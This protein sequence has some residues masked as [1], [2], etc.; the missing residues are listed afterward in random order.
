MPRTR[1]L[2]SRPR[3]RLALVTAGLVMASTVGIG[4]APSTASATTPAPACAKVDK[5]RVVLQ[6]VA[7][8][9]F[10][11][12][13]AANDQGLYAKH[14]L[15]VEIQEGGVNIVPQTVLASGN[16]EFAVTHVVKSMVS[17]EEG[18]D[19]VNISQVFQ[20]GGYLQVS[21][22]DSGIKT[23]QDL[24]GKKVGSWGFG[25]ELILYGAMRD[26]GLEPEKDST[27]VQQP[28]DMSLLLRREIDAAQAKTY[29][30]YAQLLEATNPATGEL[31]KPEDFTFLDFN[32]LGYAS[33]EDGVYARGDWLADSANQDI[34]VRFLAASYEGWA[35][36]RD[37]F[38][39][40]VEIVLN[41]GTTL[42]KGHMTWML[43]EIN[44]LIWPSPSGI[45]TMDQA[46]WDKSIKVAIDGKVLKAPPTEGAF[47]TD[48]A[49]LALALAEKSGV[50]MK[51]E[52]YQPRTVEVTP[53]GE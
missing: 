2:P 47:R 48:L 50:D 17:R 31:Y 26:A 25:N 14:C 43:N 16:S 10:A 7:Q 51:G 46:E 40:C 4:A 21:W 18:A 23:I 15:E 28:F 27:I 39:A 6:W 32:E 33:L 9:Q 35:F 41:H 45:G 37:N 19:I 11:G 34:A 5:V 12:Y 42:G 36:C 53:G 1:N 38:D 20:R 22:A 8:S 44:K 3:R 49:A 13:Y 30:E 52:N 29:N 24:K